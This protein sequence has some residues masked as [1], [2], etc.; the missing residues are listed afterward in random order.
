[1]KNVRYGCV[2]VVRVYVHNDDKIE[3]QTTRAKKRFNLNLFFSVL[4]DK[5]STTTTTTTTKS[6]YK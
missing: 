1:M 6:V 5:T 4:F 2:G 3:R